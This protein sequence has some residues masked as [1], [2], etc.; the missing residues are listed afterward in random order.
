MKRWLWY[1][2]IIASVAALGGKPSAGTDIANLQPVQVIYLSCPEGEVCIET[3]TGD[4]GMGETLK[5]A[6]E[7]MKSA[8]SREVFLDTADYLL[9]SSECIDLLPAMMEKLRPSCAISLTDG[10]P[11]MEQAGA[12]LQ[13][14][15]PTITLIKYRAGE[16]QLQTLVTREGRMELVS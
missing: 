2:G 3:D 10:G 13:Q 7:D 12:Y 15:T 16:D 5:D 8:S 14:H 6:L 11:D 4:W 1:I 9:L